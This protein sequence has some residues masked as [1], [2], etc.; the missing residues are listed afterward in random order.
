ME[1]YPQFSMTFRVIIFKADVVHLKLQDINCLCHDRCHVKQISV[2]GIAA[3][4]L[5]SYVLDGHSTS[6]SISSVR[7]KKKL[8]NLT[9]DVFM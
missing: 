2:G 3:P 6:Y 7:T 8:W 1:A 5:F 4:V 9:E